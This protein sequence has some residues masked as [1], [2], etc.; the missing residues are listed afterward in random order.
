MTSPKQIA[1]SLG[2]KSIAAAVGV[3][4]T[5]VSNAVVRGQFPPAWFVAVSGLAAAKDVECPPQAFGM[6]SP[7][8]GRAAE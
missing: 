5:A 4:E 8:S 3:R 2:R 1:D 7:D 6:R